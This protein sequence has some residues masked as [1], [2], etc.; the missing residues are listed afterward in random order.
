MTRFLPRLPLVLIPLAVALVFQGVLSAGFVTFDDRL[1]VSENPAFHPVTAASTLRLWTKPTLGLYVP[2]TY[3]LWA[4]T[5]LFAAGPDGSL[6]PRL[7]HAVSLLLHALSALLVFLILRRL[8]AP[9]LAAAAGSLLFAFHPIQV[10]AVAW[11]SAQKDLLSGLFSLVSLHRLIVYRQEGKRWNQG[12]A[13]VA[14]VLALLSKPAAVALPGMLFIV[15]TVVLGTS[16]R[17]AAW[18]LAWTFAAVPFLFI[19]Q[20]AQ[21]SSAMMSVTPLLSRPWIALDAIVF[22]LAKLVFPFGLALNYGRTPTRVLEIP[23]LVFLLIVPLTGAWFLY[24]FRS[25]TRL[26]AAGWFF[27]ALLPTLGF[28]PFHYQVHS[29]VADRFLYLSLFAPALLVARWKRGGLVG[30]LAIAGLVALTVAQVSFWRN[31][32]AVAARMA[33]VNPSVA[34]RLHR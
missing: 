23:G 6:S 27:L 30:G 12:A 9:A 2:A 14:F 33:R 22:Y 31:D 16:L 17:L 28:L 32:E 15:D 13:F 7:F 25:P 10:E 20:A 19:T 4:A 1:H 5:A 34:A 21:P 24:R 29:T 3:T 8:N 18:T 26:A 11:I